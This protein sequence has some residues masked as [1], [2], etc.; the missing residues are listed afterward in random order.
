MNY[1]LANGEKTKIQAVSLLPWIGPTALLANPVDT[2]VDAAEMP[3]LPVCIGGAGSVGQVSIIHGFA[4]FYRAF[5]AHR[6]QKPPD[7]RRE[8]AQ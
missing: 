6:P 3:D 2:V 5:T 4:R 7:G 1:G 8:D